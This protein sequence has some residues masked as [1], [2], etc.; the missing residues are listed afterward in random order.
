MRFERKHTFTAKL[1]AAA[2]S[3]SVAGAP[4]WAQK[5]K[6][7]EKKKPDFPE[8]KE[9]SKGY[10]KVVSTAD[11]QSYYTIWTRKKDGQILAELPKGYA[12]QKFFI[13][14]TVGSGYIFAGLQGSMH[15][16]YW[17]RYDKRLALIAPRTDIKA[18]GDQESKDSVAR[19]WT[20]RVLLDVPIVCMGPGGNPVIDMDAFMLGKANTFFGRSAAGANAKLAT[21]KKAKAFPLNIEV[22]IEVPVS[23]GTLRTFHYS[24]SKVQTTKGFKPREADDR[25][26]YFTVG[27]RDLGKFRDDDVPVT[28]ITRWPLEKRDPKLKMSPPKEPLIYYIEHTV[29]VR[30][31]RYVK[32]G[33]LYWNKAFEQ[34]GLLDAIEVRYQDKVT[35]AHMEKDP[36]DVRYN[37]IRWLNNDI[38]TAIG[39]SRPHPD[40]GEILDA[41]IILTDGW[42]RHFWYQ[43]TDYL[44][45]VAMEGF[46]PETIA[47]FDTHPNWDPRLRLA[48][49]QDR[50]RLLYERAQRM[51]S[52]YANPIAIDPMLINDEIAS[53]LAYQL[54]DATLLCMAANGKARDMA[55][56]GMHM[57]M[58]GILDDEDDEDDD[59][60][61]DEETGDVLDGIPE[62]FVG[63]MLADLVA[64]EVGHTLGL[65]HN[66]KASTVYTLEE[67]NSEDFKGNKTITGSVMDYTPVNINMDDGEIQGD[68]AMIDIGPYDMWAIEYGYTSGDTEDILKRAAEPELIYGTDEDTSGSDPRG[69]RYDFA[70]NPLNYANSRM[71]L[72]ELHRSKII[73]KFVKEGQGWHKARRGYRITLGTQAGALSIMSRWI[74]GTYTNR[75]HKGDP[76]DRKPVTPI[77][78]ETQRAALNFIIDNAFND[79]AF[80]L[81]TELLSYMTVDKK[82]G[83]NRDEEAY[84]IHDSI[85][86][87]QASALSMLMNP[88]T[89]RRVYDNEYRTPADEDQLTLP[90]LLETINNAIWTE[91]DKRP[92]KRF[93]ARKPM[94]SSLRRNLQR[95]HLERI[96]D[97]TKPDAGFTAAYKPISNLAFMELRVLKGRIDS[98]LEHGD[99]K[100][101]PYTSAHLTEATL[102]IAKV[103]D[104]SYI[105]NAN[106]MGGGG[107]GMPFFF[108]K[109]TEDDN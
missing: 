28:Y 92:D 62:W 8:F 34:V 27:H 1:L 91:I 53:D 81:T 4:A 47:W 103:L 75:D 22:A 33:L 95:E 60:N 51:A 100:L 94:I 63:P 99:S 73:D 50:P 104:A 69:R 101:D 71:R 23:G 66:F 35:G 89:L 40:T 48:S 84:N 6:K 86:G 74:G 52:G 30:Y 82:T 83:Y 49:P 32:Q 72:V 44:P 21:I 65:R 107:G 7:D 87:V 26:G 90:E 45:Q 59:E 55:L 85:L 96:I 11:G 15:Y 78:A 108:F 105:Y 41:D 31:R 2:I 10:E 61:G 57:E 97:L 77:D 39:P 56:M 54:G 37:F 80:G 36:E 76:G 102:R 38:G 106:D 19:I 42:I 9:V 18:T 29:P 79:E 25:I 68:Y 14:T 16:V 5:D 43:Y 12:N 3:L 93:S 64:H 67:M 24:I 58:L 70:K 46:T 17:K 109:P 20:D 98:M 13:A 88:T